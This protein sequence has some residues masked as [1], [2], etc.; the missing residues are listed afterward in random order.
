MCTQRCTHMGLSQVGKVNEFSCQGKCLMHIPK[1]QHPDWKICSNNLLANS[2][3]TLRGLTFTHSR[4]LAHSR[5]NLLPGSNVIRSPHPLS[6]CSRHSSQQ[7][8]DQRRER[9]KKRE[10]VRRGR[11]GRERVQGRWGE[12]RGKDE[13]KMKYIEQVRILTMNTLKTRCMAAAAVACPPADVRTSAES[14][15]RNSSKVCPGAGFCTFPL[16]LSALFS[17]NPLA[18]LLVAQGPSGP[19]RPRS[20]GAQGPLA[21]GKMADS[22]QRY[23]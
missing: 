17:S 20:Q 14:H 23:L 2:T 4:I 5:E 22:E 1:S 7:Q 6:L 12:W 19:S 13:L 11:G 21:Q 9:G 10:G 8:S 3:H 15:P 16:I 18:L